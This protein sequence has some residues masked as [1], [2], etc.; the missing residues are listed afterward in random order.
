MKKAVEREASMNLC[1]IVSY[2]GSR[3]AGW[4]KNE[5]TGA[6]RALQTV[7]ESMLSDYL[8]QPVQVKAAGRTDAGVHA[9][10]QVLHFHVRGRLPERVQEKLPAQ[11]AG[12]SDFYALCRELNEE[13]YCSLRQEEKGA[14]VI[15]SVRRV[16]ERFHSRYDAVGKTY[17]YYFDERERES[18][19]AR[20]Y[21]YPAGRRLDIGAMRAAAEQ[22][23]G[24]HDFLMFSSVRAGEK[25]TVRT[26]RT[27]QIER[28]RKEHFPCELVRFSVTGDGFLYH[29]ARILAGT[30]YEVGIGKRTVQ[31]VREALNG[32]VR[33]D[34]GILLPGSALFLRE[35]YYE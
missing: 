13:L 7:F 26:I 24:T 4:Q 25:D 22:L 8:G 28:V 12:D 32:G 5:N 27:I 14:V 29:M 10:G 6:R 18:V 35:I 30:V 3:F 1:M 33:A 15:R 21:A 23:V 20:A 19:F 17:D 2:D 31:S 9:V 11:A 34:T 16:P